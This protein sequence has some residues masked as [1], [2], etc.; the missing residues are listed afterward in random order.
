[1]DEL[2]D[3]V[4][5]AKFFSKIDLRT[6]FHQIR[7]ADADIEKT[8]FRTRYGS[9]EYLVLPMGLCNAPGTFMQLM[10]DTFRDMLDKSVLVF[11]DDILIF[12]RTKEEH[13][14]HVR[15]VF[16][17]LREQKLYAKR[18]KCEF[19]RDE[20]EFLGH[21]IGANGLSVSQD[22]ISAVRDWPAPKNVSEVRSFLGLAGF[23]R[24]FVKDFSKVALPITELTKEKTVPWEWGP[25]QSEAVAALK[26]ALCTAPV[27]LIPD[28]SRPYTLNCDACMY[29]V[30]ATLQQDHGNGLQP[31]AFRSKKLSPAEINYDTREKEFLALV[32][33]CS[34]WRHYLHG[35]QKFT[36]LSDHDS[37]K[38][39]KSMPHLSGRLARWMEKMAEFD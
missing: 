31:V 28:P 20:V 16:E 26:P 1:M 36:L 3:R 39:H 27:L 8:A 6:G 11:L 29:A 22:K 17:R 38:Y 12:S 35:T 23:Y 34:Y 21:R 5:G 37:L 10:N 9:F 30:G 24:R 15:Q 33:A 25:R 14:Q 32:D 19:F 13:E 4:H 2:F 18:S 7:V